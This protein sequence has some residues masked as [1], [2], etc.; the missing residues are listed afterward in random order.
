VQGNRAEA[1]VKGKENETATMALVKE[2][3][4]WR[5]SDLGAPA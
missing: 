5:I 3:G 4:G 1:E 2:R